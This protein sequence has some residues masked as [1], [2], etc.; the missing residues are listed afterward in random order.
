MGNS[1]FIY[2]YRH[3]L[4]YFEFS[5]AG[6][7]AC[8]LVFTIVF[9]LMKEIPAR[10]QSYNLATM[11][12][13]SNTLIILLLICVQGYLVS[14]ANYHINGRDTSW[15]KA[16]TFFMACNQTFYAH[17]SWLRGKEVFKMQ[18][19]TRTYRTLKY[20]LQIL[21]ALSLGP[22]IVLLISMTR[23]QTSLAYLLTGASS[24][25]A[26]IILDVFYCF[27][28][29]RQIFN[30]VDNTISVPVSY[31][32]IANYGLGASICA[33]LLVLTFVCNVLLVDDESPSQNALL[34]YAISNGL[35]GTLLVLNGIILVMMKVAL[36]KP[37]FLHGT[38]TAANIRK[39]LDTTEKLAAPEI[40]VSNRTLLSK[41]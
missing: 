21:P 25:L 19:S 1:T 4:A 9:T 17:Y 20:V 36:I 7:A 41:L 38:T 39:F 10:S 16:E 6:V 24:G 8:L 13:P 30:M 32:T 22:F 33:L 31:R 14:D 27:S 12:S 18:T 15:N 29:L 37:A 2:E 5:L 35:F 11:F 34:A 23:E 3:G 28:F 40:Q 26:T